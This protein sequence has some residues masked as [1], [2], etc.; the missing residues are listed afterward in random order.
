MRCCSTVSARRAAGCHI[1]D[2]PQI[3]PMFLMGSSLVRALQFGRSGA[4]QSTAVPGARCCIFEVSSSQVTSSLYSRWLSIA[5][6]CVPRSLLV[7]LL[8]SRCAARPPGRYAWSERPRSAKRPGPYECVPAAM[9]HP[10]HRR[11]GGAGS[12]TVELASFANTRGG[13]GGGIVVVHGDWMQR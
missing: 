1:C 9:Y 5:F 11:S 4:A 13:H 7:G 10:W 8:S 12:A 3:P 2:G 6:P